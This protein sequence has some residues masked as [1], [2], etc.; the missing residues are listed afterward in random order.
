MSRPTLAIDLDGVLV[1]FNDTYTRLLMKIEPGIKV[2]LFAA[3][4]PPCWEY[5]THY[6]FSKET[7]RKAWTEIRN[8][9]IFWRFLFPY[10]NA[11]SDLRLL[12]QMDADIYFVTTRPG[13]T[14]KRET[15]QWLESQGFFGPT[16]VIAGNKLAFCEAVGATHLIDDKPENLGDP[17]VALPWKRALFKRPYNKDYWGKYDASVESVREALN[18]L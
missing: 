1:N 3:D 6:G 16:V 17:A 14:A 5:D 11:P 8:S 12:R 18:G 4:F 9:G 2:D 7:I 13:P 10:A 15:E